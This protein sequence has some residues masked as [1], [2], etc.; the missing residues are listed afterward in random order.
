MLLISTPQCKYNIKIERE[1]QNAAKQN[2]KEMNLMKE[3]SEHG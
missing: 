2:R 1:D 3:M